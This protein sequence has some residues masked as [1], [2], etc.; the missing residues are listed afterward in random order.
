MNRD[1][2]A[3]KATQDSLG[4]LHDLEILIGRARHEQASLSATTLT[5][6]CELDL[7][8]R[9]LEDG[10]RTLHARFVGDRTK[11]MG[12]ANRIGYSKKA[13]RF[14]Q[15]TRSRLGPTLASSATGAIV[16]EDR[17]LE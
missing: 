1:I 13:P 16:A 10:C 8:V 5:A 9:A 12:T 15:P 14:R 11:L 6:S 2:N 7:L 4:R 3:L 17:V